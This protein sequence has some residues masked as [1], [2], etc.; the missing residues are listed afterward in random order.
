MNRADSHP[1]YLEL[2]RLALNRAAPETAAHVAQCTRCI[3]HI[4]QLTPVAPPPAWLGQLQP[5]RARARKRTL[6]A[7][8]GGLAMAAALCLALLRPDEPAYDGAKGAPAVAVHVNREGRVALWDH[9]PLRPGDRI[10]LEVAAAEFEYVSVFTSQGSAKLS[11]MYSGRVPSHGQTL[12]PKAWLLDAAPGPE[13]LLVMFS[14]AELSE[15]A[16]STLLKAHD[17]KDIAIVWLTLPKSTR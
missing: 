3:A 5:P 6:A 2:D 13:R 4:A 12:L 11:A 8:L 16:A 10:R 15:Q 14:H 1:S 7:A 9:G 17:P